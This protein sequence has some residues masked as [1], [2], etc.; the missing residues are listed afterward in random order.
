LVATL[1]VAVAALIGV[2]GIVGYTL[3]RPSPPS[4]ASAASPTTSSAPAVQPAPPPAPNPEPKTSSSSALA[5]QYFKTPFGT[6]CEV[7]AQHVICQTCVPGETFSVDYTCTDPPSTV[8]VDPPS[9]VDHNPR[10]IGNPSNLQK[11]SDGDSFHA[12]G[13]TIVASG[14]WARFINDATGHG[15]AVAPTNFDSF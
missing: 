6:L 1:V 14:N 5:F 3:L 13:W 15:M 7:A 9:L 11:L 4:D 8:A 10:F 12:N 2:V